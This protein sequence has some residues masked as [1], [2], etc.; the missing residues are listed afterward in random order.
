METTNKTS[1][2]AVVQTHPIQYHAPLYR[3]VQQQFKI[4]VTVIYGSDFS[5]AGY[6]DKEFKS[7]FAWDTDLL[8]GY[9]SVFLSR[10]SEGGA[11]TVEKISANGMERELRKAEPNAVL[12]CGYNSFFHQA[13]FYLALRLKLPI[14]FRADTGDDAIVKRNLVKT[15]LRSYALRWLYQKCDKLLYIGKFSYE[16][17]RRHG[18]PDTKLIF[19]PY[20][21]DSAPFQCSETDRIRY[22][23]STRQNF[24]VQGNEKLLLFSGKLIPKKAP[25]QVLEA[26]KKLPLEI[27]GKIIVLFMGDGELKEQLKK[28]ATEPPIIKTYFS[29]FQNQTEVSRYYHAADLLIVP[30]IHSETWGVVVNDALHHGLPCIVSKG[31]G[32]GP[33]LITE[34]V[35]GEIFETGSAS[36]LADALQRA[37]SLVGRSEVRNQCRDKVKDYTIEKAAEGIAEAY[38]DLIHA[39]V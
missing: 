16:H 3:A 5:I 20:C 38:N 11:N 14:I 31:V 10:V 9:T 2:L 29:G 28:Q 33:D 4:P 37:F 22:R 35:T 30:S 8:T 17:F 27:R 32:S 21:A 1:G 12:I 19:S 39:C 18:C 26:V 6:Q 34:G 13:A 15:W 36:S 23:D 25:G 7:T 24:S